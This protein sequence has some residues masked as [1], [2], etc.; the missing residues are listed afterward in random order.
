MMR[1]VYG[2]IQDDLYEACPFIS[3]NA[4]LY[5]L[6]HQF[7]FASLVLNENNDFKVDLG[8]LFLHDLWMQR[9]K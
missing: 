6:V 5:H 2:Y 3:K 8:T 1:G 7:W 4:L 9:L